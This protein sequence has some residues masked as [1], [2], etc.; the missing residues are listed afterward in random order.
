[1]GSATSKRRRIDGSV[2]ADCSNSGM[3]IQVTYIP[4]RIRAVH[5]ALEYSRY[6]HTNTMESKESVQLFGAMDTMYRNSINFIPN[7]S[8]KSSQ[9]NVPFRLSFIQLPKILS[10]IA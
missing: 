6:L 5:R 7:V 4:G 1:M 3:W 2:P 9:R 8:Y 10:C